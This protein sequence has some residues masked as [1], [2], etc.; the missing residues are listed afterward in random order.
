MAIKEEATVLEMP[1]WLKWREVCLR[2]RLTFKSE[3]VASPFPNTEATTNAPRATS[4]YTASPTSLEFEFPKAMV[5]GFSNR[6][7]VVGDGATIFHVPWLTL[8][9]RSEHTLST[10]ARSYQQHTHHFL[11]M[12]PISNASHQ[13]L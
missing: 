6:R 2:L 4:R 9:T 1:C 11:I 12:S 7:P 5:F 3:E 13:L 8:G 10:Q